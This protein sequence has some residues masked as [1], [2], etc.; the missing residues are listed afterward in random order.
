MSGSSTL[1]PSADQVVTVSISAEHAEMLASLQLP[2]ESLRE[3]LEEAVIA[4][5]IE[6]ERAA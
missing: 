3:A 1:A 5:W 4:L 6:A 2:G